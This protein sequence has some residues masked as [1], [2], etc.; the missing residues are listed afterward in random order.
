M[1]A[2]T[3]LPKAVFSATISH[4]LARKLPDFDHENGADGSMCDVEFFPRP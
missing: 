3:D 2:D 1:A 4:L